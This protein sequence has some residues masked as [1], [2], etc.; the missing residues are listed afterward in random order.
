LEGKA[1]MILLTNNKEEEELKK[2]IKPWKMGEDRYN[3]IEARLELYKVLR[4]QLWNDVQDLMKHFLETNDKR[5]LKLHGEV[6]STLT[7]GVKPSQNEVV[8]D[9]AT[10]NC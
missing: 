1:T 5:A 3:A 7:L 9:P 2:H 6:I 4:K 10:H 8:E